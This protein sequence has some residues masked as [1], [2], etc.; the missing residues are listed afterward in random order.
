[1]THTAEQHGYWV[2][3][4]SGNCD[5][6]LEDLL[7][8]AP[9]L[10][11]TK[12]VAVV[13]C[14]GGPY[15][16]SADELAAGWSL[17]GNV[18]ISGEVTDPLDLPTPGFDE[19]YVF[20]AV[21]GIVPTRVHVNRYNFSVFDESDEAKSFWEQVVNAQPLHVLGAGTPCSSLLVTARLLNL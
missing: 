2:V 12:R 8:V 5:P 11:R 21:P 18:A 19:W 7:V 4:W 13:A 16:P 6:S 17:A 14:D 10:V 15:T 1:M 3:Q 20:D 9:A